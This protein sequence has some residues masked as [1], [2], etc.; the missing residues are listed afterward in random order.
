M[1]VQHIEDHPAHYWKSYKVLKD[2]FYQCSPLY[3]I[4]N[5][6]FQRKVVN[7]LPKKDLLKILGIGSGRGE[8]D[9]VNIRRMLGHVSRINNTVVE[10]S[11]EAIEAY[12]SL[13]C[14]DLSD[15]VNTSWYNETFQQYQKRRDGNVATDKFHFISAVHSLYYVDNDGRSIDYLIDL[16]EKDGVLFIIIQN[17]NNHFLCMDSLRISNHPKTLKY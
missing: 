9:C 1:F 16:L 3:D 12:K 15:R 4:G 7:V 10:P 5:D 6:A 13:I 8:L 2:N 14:G 17:G 11:V